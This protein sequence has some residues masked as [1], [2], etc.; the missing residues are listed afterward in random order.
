M[1]LP[2][3]RLLLGANLALFYIRVSSCGRIDFEVLPENADQAGFDTSPFTDTLEEPTTDRSIDSENG[4][5]SDPESSESDTAL[6]V[7]STSEGEQETDGAG[8]TDGPTE[9]EPESDTETHIGADVCPN[10]TGGTKTREVSSFVLHSRDAA[11]ETVIGNSTYEVGH[12]YTDSSD[13]EMTN[14]VEYHGPQQI[15][16]LRF[17]SVQIPRGAV[18]QEARVEFVADFTNDEPTNLFVTV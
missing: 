5:I 15:I 1:L 11:E 9:T 18:I 6:D 14:D 8:N 10:I 16:G 13:L 4:T 7:D 17:P 3:F 12:T 2:R